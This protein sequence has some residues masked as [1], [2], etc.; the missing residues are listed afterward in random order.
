M[1]LII[2]I[3]KNIL[4]KS[5]LKAPLGRWNIET[6]DKKLNNKID[7]ANQDHCG[8]CGK[9]IR[10]VKLNES[11]KSVHSNNMGVFQS[12]IQKFMGI[13]DI[14]KNILRID[15]ISKKN[16]SRLSVINQPT[17]VQVYLPTYLPTYLPAYQPTNLHIHRKILSKLD[18]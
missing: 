8:P 17:N 15:E 14:R 13:S 12:S 4:Q 9:Y 11:V 5:N 10:I 3:I 7:L 1:M 18:K 2:T 6:C 16:S